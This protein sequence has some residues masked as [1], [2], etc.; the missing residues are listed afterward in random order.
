VHS[1]R[2]LFPNK[3]HTLSVRAY[4]STLLLVCGACRSHDSH[5]TA[6]HHS[7]SAM[8]R[9]HGNPIGLNLYVDA[10]MGVLRCRLLGRFTDRPGAT[11]SR[12]VASDVNSNFSKIFL[13]HIQMV[14]PHTFRASWYG[15]VDYTSTPN[16][17]TSSLP[18]TFYFILTV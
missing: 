11:D 8:L 12:R 13:C 3:T 10:F 16:V 6:K 1:Y 5:I 7:N 15:Y 14:L 17:Y 4:S 2:P 9:R 18:H